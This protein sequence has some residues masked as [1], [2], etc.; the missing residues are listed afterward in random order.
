MRSVKTGANK[1]YWGFNQWRWQHKAITLVIKLWL[2]KRLFF[3]FKKVLNY[4]ITHF[5]WANSSPSDHQ[6]LTWQIFE[7]CFQVLTAWPFP[8]ISNKGFIFSVVNYAS[9]FSLMKPTTT[10]VQLSH[11]TVRYFHWQTLPYNLSWVLPSASGDLLCASRKWMVVHCSK[12]HHKG[13]E[14]AVMSFLHAQKS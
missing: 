7:S 1:K 10:Q 2:R 5:F 8:D 11:T 12:L 4:F 9:W 13:H 3:F 6:R 14:K